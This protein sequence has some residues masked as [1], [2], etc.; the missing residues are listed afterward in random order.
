LHLISQ[1]QNPQTE[2]DN[3]TSMKRKQPVAIESNASIEN[4]KVDSNSKRKVARHSLRVD[5]YLHNRLLDHL[6]MVKYVY[7]QDFSKT[8]WIKEAIQEKLERDGHRCPE[9]LSKD[10][11]VN[12]KVTREMNEQ[13][14]NRV[15]M[16]QQK[17]PGFSKK[18]WIIESF[19]AKLDRD[20][21]KAKQTLDEKI[22]L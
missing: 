17:R 20:E 18:L 4:S 16:I 11:Y 13:I 15:K 6:N 7:Q 8:S 12:I 3:Y 10:Q 19:Y 14:E 21:I 9:E 2:M 1:V 5:D 22:C